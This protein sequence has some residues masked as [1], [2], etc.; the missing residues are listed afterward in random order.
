L[1]VRANSSWCGAGIPPGTGSCEELWQCRSLLPS[2]FSLLQHLEQSLEELDLTSF[3]LMDTTLEE[4]FLKVSEE[5]QSLE[6]SDVG[7]ACGELVVVLLA[8]G[9]GGEVKASCAF[10]W[11]VPAKGRLPFVK[12]ICWMRHSK[13]CHSQQQLSPSSRHEGVQEGCP[14]ATRP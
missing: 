7:T 6:N 3:G 1:P 4:V 12:Q 13:G 9:R 8:G 5:D 2:S 14:A 11:A 10:T